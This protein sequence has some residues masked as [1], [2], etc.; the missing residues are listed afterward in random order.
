MRHPS[1]LV[2]PQWHSWLIHVDV[3]I[4]Y[5]TSGKTQLCSISMIGVH[6]H[7]RH[8][9]AWFSFERRFD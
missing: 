7:H 1:L 9:L 5:F 8:N 2:F 6:R 4:H 3:F